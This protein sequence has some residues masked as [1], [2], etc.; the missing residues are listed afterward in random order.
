MLNR[1]FVGSGFGDLIERLLLV[2]L[3]AVV[4][5]STKACSAEQKN[6]LLIC[7]DDLRPELASFGV[8]FI[9][10]PNI[11]DLAKRGVSFQRHYVNAPSCGC[12]RFTLL[13]GMYGSATNQALFNRAATINKSA[14]EVP[15]SMPEWFRKIGYTTVF[16]RLDTP[17]FRSGKYRITRAGAV[18]K[19]GMIRKW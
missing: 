3:L 11:D 12:S 6:V 1:A 8:S 4:F 18:A 15:L 10:S 5:L 7:V 17:L 16:G 14:G 9:H 2:V 13:T 19:I